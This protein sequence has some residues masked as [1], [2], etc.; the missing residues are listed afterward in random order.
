LNLE[1]LRGLSHPER[2]IVL[3]VKLSQT[4]RRLA[5][6][7]LVAARLQTTSGGPA[8]SAG[9]RSGISVMIQMVGGCPDG[10]PPLVWTVAVPVAFSASCCCL[11]LYCG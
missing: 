3:V 9:P 7:R 4:H 10:R 1:Q 2:G 6:D 11:E 5:F 8:G